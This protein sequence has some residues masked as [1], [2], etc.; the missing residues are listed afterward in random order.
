MSPIL[1][2]LYHHVAPFSQ[3]HERVDRKLFVASE[4]FQNQIA[5]LKRNFN[6][7]SLET[8]LMGLRGDMAMNHPSVVLSFDDGH[9]DNYSYAFPIAMENACPLIIYLCVRW[10]TTEPW[11]WR[12]DIVDLIHSIPEI[13]FDYE[14]NHYRLATTNPRLR[15]ETYQS[16]ARMFVHRTKA[17][18]LGLLQQIMISSGRKM[19]MRPEA[20]LSWDEIAEMDR[21]DIITF[22]SHTMNH[23]LLASVDEQS[24]EFELFESKRILEER[25]G[26]EVADLA[27]PYGGSN[28]AGQRE[29]EAA[30]NAGYQS[31]IT[32]LP[33]LCGAAW[34]QSPFGMPRVSVDGRWGQA[35][36]ESQV[37]TWMQTEDL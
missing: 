12:L 25:L 23:P 24:L 10:L 11:L 6:C 31:S 35:E 22:G 17:E 19:R 34:H 2:L 32:T 20:F 26:H 21:Q 33:G 1:I 5:F 3:V 27:Y 8:A 28:A 37:K 14:D 7:I 16:L 4:D 18:Q 15:Q 30:K 9:K 36:F 29:H 13:C